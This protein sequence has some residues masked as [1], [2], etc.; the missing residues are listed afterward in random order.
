MAKP[1]EWDGLTVRDPFNL[2]NGVV[3]VV[4]EGIDSLKLEVRL[5]GRVGG[6]VTAE[7]NA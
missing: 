7:I 6:L 5:K 2:A 1:T 4:A 3:I